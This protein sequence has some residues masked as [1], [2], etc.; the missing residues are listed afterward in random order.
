MFI[1]L[2]VI[3]F[4]T[5]VCLKIHFGCSHYFENKNM[6]THAGLQT[7]RKHQMHVTIV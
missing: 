7:S 5:T 6:R 4:C 3:L 1:I 2:S